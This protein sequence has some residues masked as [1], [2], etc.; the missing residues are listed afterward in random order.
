MNLATL[1]EAQRSGDNPLSRSRPETWIIAAFVAALVAGISLRLWRLGI[2]PAWQWDEAVYWKVSAN[3]QRGVLA[4]HSAY[5]LPWEPFLYQPP[6]Y[7]KI[8][9]TWFDLVGASI[10]TARLFG[11]GC[12]AVM[13]VLLFSLLWRLNRPRVALLRRAASDLRWLAPLH[14]A[15]LIY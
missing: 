10:Y 15:N 9:A 14:R 12:T 8:L 7:F 3:V 1:F 13:Q 11:V 5:R 4:E 2:S 6:V